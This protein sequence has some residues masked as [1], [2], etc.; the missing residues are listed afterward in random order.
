MIVTLPQTTPSEINFIL[1]FRRQLNDL[2]W[3]GN[4]GGSRFHFCFANK[5]DYAA[6]K[7]RLKNL[8]K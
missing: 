3:D 7:R 8:R 6:A 4:D 2:V 5:A 1:D